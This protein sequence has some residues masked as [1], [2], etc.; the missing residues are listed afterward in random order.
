MKKAFVVSV[1]APS[2]MVLGI[3]LL[4]VFVAGYGDEAESKNGDFTNTKPLEST[5]AEGANMGA[6]SHVN[7]RQNLQNATNL[8]GAANLP[9]CIS[10][11][12]A[13]FARFQDIWQKAE[14]NNDMQEI[15]KANL[16]AIHYDMREKSKPMDMREYIVYKPRS[17]GASEADSSGV[18]SGVSESN[19]ADFGEIV[20]NACTPAWCEVSTYSV[21]SM[22]TRE[23]LMRI[24]LDREEGMAH[25]VW[26]EFL[27]ARDFGAESSAQNS[28][29]S[30]EAK[31]SRGSQ[32][33]RGAQ[34]L[35]DSQKS[36][37]AKIDSS[38]TDLMGNSLESVPKGAVR[39]F[40]ADEKGETRYIGDFSPLK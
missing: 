12:N 28:Q 33:S 7:E 4:A 36:D 15:F 10:V 5:H 32:K 19:R 40:I 18:D 17:V 22:Q 8:Q 23:N 31:K 14:S 6:P 9:T 30:K 34:K 11:E 16:Q 37:S 25:I 2:V 39:I 29:K 1:V 24:E 35:E 13:Y 20:Y 21:R 3:V 27:F 26:L 38:S